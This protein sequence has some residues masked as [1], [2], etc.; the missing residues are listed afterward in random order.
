MNGKATSM[1][2]RTRGFPWGAAAGALLLAGAPAQ[3]QTSAA[4]RPAPVSELVR[5]VNIPYEEFTL[6]NGLRVVTHT[7][8]K[9][10]IVAVSVWYGVGSKDEPPGRTGFAH[11]FEHL[12]FNG[13][14]NA[15]GEFFEPL[16]N[17]GATDFNGTTWF[18]RTNYF[19]NVPTPALELALFLE[20]DRMGYLLG[21]VTQENL[22]NQIGVVQNEKRQGDNQ[23][24]GL[25][26]YAILEG[27]FPEGHPYRHSTIGSMADLSAATL[28]TVREWFRTHYGPNNAVLVLAGDIDARTA[29]PLVE[30][31]FGTIP[32]GRTP[33]KRT[34]GVPERTAVTRVTL[35]DQ[36]ANP[37]IYRVWAVPGRLSPETPLLDA[38]AAVLGGGTTSRLYND[39][40]RDKQLAVAV[41]GYLQENQL[42]SFLQLEVDVRP[43]VEVAAVEAR[44]D[45]LMADFLRTGPT[46]DEVSR[47][48]TRA[49]AGT[50]RGLEEVGGFGGKAVTLAEG[51]LYANDP[52]FYRRQLDI[53]AR[54]TPQTVLA[55]SRRWINDGDLRLTVLQGPR[56]ADESAA[57]A[58]APAGAQDG[59][60]AGGVNRPRFYRQPGQP[61]GAQPVV[62]APTPP[63]AAEQP[64]RPTSPAP[65]EAAIPA[66]GVQQPAPVAPPQPTGQPP[67]Q[68]TQ[69]AQ[70][71][72]AQPLADEGAPPRRPTRPQPRPQV[73]GFAALDFPAVERAR[74][75]NGMEVQFVRRA[76][77]PVVQMALSFDAG[78]ASDSPDKLG[79]A[80]L[81]ATLLDEGTGRR[82]SVQIAEEAE[83]LGASLAAGA[84]LDRTRVF[85][86]A[87]KPN[88]AAS[89][90]LMADVVRNPAFPPAEVERLRTIQLNRIAQELTQPSAIA[91]RE[92]AP[93]IYGPD[94]PYGK[95]LTGSGTPEGVR[96]ITLAD[97]RA[98]QQRWLRPDNATLFVVGDATL[99]ELRPQLERAFGAWSAPAVARGTKRFITAPTPAAGR[100]V[101]IDRPNSPQSVI[102][103]GLALPLEGTDDPLQLNAAN[104]I[105]GGSFISRL[106]TELRERKGWSYGVRSSVQPV[107]EQLPF[108]VSAPVQTD[109]TADSL[110]T[111]VDLTR[112]FQGAQPPTPQELSLVINSNV[113]SLPGSYETSNEVLSALERNA[114]LGRP[115]DYLERLAA[116][117]QALTPGELSAA[118]RVIDPA[119]M[120][121]VIVGDRARVEAPLRAL[122]LGAVEVRAAAPAAPAAGAGTR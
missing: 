113:R 61:A 60:G 93:L 13:S 107:R 5:A 74:L 29:R 102:L 7:D 68:A 32:R 1:A 40:V 35:R 101:L 89:L 116:R 53:Y 62:P 18:D 36:V 109:R 8:R 104:E 43:G 87:L 15:P 19:Q 57:R 90:E 12:M 58:G 55:A 34:A 91:S 108:I 81:T 117:Y 11:L 73:Q 16:E 27:L 96:S 50:I 105:L 45:Q 59:G 54:A 39:L 67:A 111:L 79:L 41:R 80:T 21:A 20:S 77:V 83:R 72:E 52:G 118:A 69:E 37:R 115:D 24:Y 92:I 66:T 95:P 71:P 119:R 76:T 110:K 26:E 65:G 46:A 94:H 48:A 106:N 97:L 103:G 38:A 75:S 70:A 51:E 85:M 47:V 23:P 84:S 17:V 112:A 120:T 9:V 30:T 33:P 42:A 78:T 28:D 25:T 63:R 86:S 6:A 2:A 122:N 49:V 14:E 99:A 22:T 4:A 31:Y 88:L 56:P 3:A 44:L 100:I 82:T 114:L 98:Y 64:A 121:W 10:P